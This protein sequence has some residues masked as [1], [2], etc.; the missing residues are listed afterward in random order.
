M[1]AKIKMLILLFSSMAAFSFKADSINVV[2]QLWKLNDPNDPYNPAKYS[3]FTTPLPSCPSESRVCYIDIGPFDLIPIGQP[4]AGLPNVIDDP[5][6]PYELYD[7]IRAALH[8]FGNDPFAG[9]SNRIIY[10]RN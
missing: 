4:N 2:G 6:N 1:Y 10:E 7:D 9:S 3:T 8:E 5:F